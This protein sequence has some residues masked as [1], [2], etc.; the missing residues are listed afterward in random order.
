MMIKKNNYSSKN[1][2]NPN[3]DIILP[4]YFSEEDGKNEDFL[5]SIKNRFND[6]FSKLNYNDKDNK[7]KVS[8]EIIYGAI[9][10]KKLGFNEHFE[11]K[12]KYQRVDID[13]I[14]EIQKLF[15]GYFIRNINLKVDKL[16]LRKCLIELFC[17]LLYGLYFKGKIRYYFNILKE[18][19]KSTRYC[20]EEEFNFDDK[21]KFILPQ[22][23]YNDTKINDLNA[24]N[25]EN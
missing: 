23:F 25:F 3:K 20:V 5:S 10:L 12:R 8:N 9:M 19:Y 6:I 14:I 1:T 7:K 17:L 18:I 22:E 15:R 13:K 21:M 16:K 24:I 2:I 11:H 4:T